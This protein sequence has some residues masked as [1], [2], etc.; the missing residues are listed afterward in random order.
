[1]VTAI[2]LVPYFLKLVIQFNTPLRGA[3][4]STPLRGEK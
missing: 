1:M 4:F 3:L 2:T